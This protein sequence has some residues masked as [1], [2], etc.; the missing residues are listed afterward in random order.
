MPTFGDDGVL[1]GF[2]AD[3]AGEGNTLQQ[4]LIVIIL[5]LL[6]GLACTF[7]LRYDPSTQF[8]AVGADLP[9]AIQLPSLFVVFSRVKELA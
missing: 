9:V 3:D 5:L 8:L 1:V 7:A 6:V 4:F 2:P